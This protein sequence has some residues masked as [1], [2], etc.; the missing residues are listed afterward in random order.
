MTQPAPRDVTQLLTAWS[1]GDR[2]ALDQLMP[3]VYDELS[4]LARH[5]MKRERP[6]H[7]LQTTALVNEAYLRLADQKN[8]RWQNRAH[9]F[10]IAAQLMRRI[11]VDHARG[12]DHIKRGGGAQRVP[13]DEAAVLAPE[14]AAEV[15]ALDD[16]LRKLAE[17]DP[18][19]CQVVE[20]RY[21][22]GLTVDEIAEVLKVSPVT[23]MRDWSM[24]KAWLH[25]E[26][27]NEG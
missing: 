26:M 12:R 27:S 25:R 2:A 20:M 3:L 8:T 15:V 21:F 5:Y 11:L 4:R 16:A 17:N 6:G 9:F 23:V 10:G 24:A 1:N 14:K 22:G 19:K 18:R 7:T 13:L